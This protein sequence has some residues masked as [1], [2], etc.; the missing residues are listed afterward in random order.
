M[1]CQCPKCAY[2]HSSE[3]AADY[4]IAWKITGN[5]SCNSLEMFILYIAICMAIY[6]VNMQHCHTPGDNLLGWEKQL[7]YLNS[8]YAPLLLPGEEV[9]FWQEL[10]RM[11]SKGS[12]K[13]KEWRKVV[14]TKVT[15]CWEIKK[16]RT[17]AWIYR[18]RGG[19][20]AEFKVKHVDWCRWTAVAG[21]I[22]GCYHEH[23]WK[24][25]E[26]R[27]TTFYTRKKR[28]L[29]KTQEKKRLAVCLQSPDVRR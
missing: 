4:I 14:N 23:R 8:K 19:T 13:W 18:W 28:K 16:I 11:T 21:Q 3:S 20:M 6:S 17:V 26:K 1:H 5:F 2:I 9:V 22:N 12:V 10:E 7:N 15:T 24:E 29:K 27:R 25:W